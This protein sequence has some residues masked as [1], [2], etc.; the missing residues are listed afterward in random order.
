M[1]MVRAFESSDIS[2]LVDI[3]KRNYEQEFPFPF[4][5]ARAF[6]DEKFVVEDEY[7]NIITFGALEIALEAVVMT[8]KCCPIK[9]R[10]EALYKLL[11]ALS[12]AAEGHGFDM[13][14]CT[15]QDLKW[16]EHLKRA[17]FNK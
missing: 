17:G 4:S 2:K 7:H 14:H 11:Q 16:L 5:G 15:I 9:Q 1:V 3:H 13:F 6:L 12:F 10:R 8:D